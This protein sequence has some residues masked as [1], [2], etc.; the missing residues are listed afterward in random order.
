MLKISSIM[1]KYLKAKWLGS[2]G[3][4]QLPYASN[5]ESRGQR[6]GND[7]Y[8]GRP[9]SNLG[10]ST[11]SNEGLELCFLWDLSS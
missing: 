11:D 1:L 9:T 7:R 10:K 8:H 2:H 5:S 3:V 4:A 6:E